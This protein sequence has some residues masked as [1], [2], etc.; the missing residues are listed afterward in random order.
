MQDSARRDGDIDE[1]QD[2]AA[3]VANH[4]DVLAHREIEG[5][6]LALR[7]VLPGGGG[8]RKLEPVG[9]RPLSFQV[10]RPRRTVTVP[11]A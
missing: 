9:P 1:T 7:N 6:R 11:A 3:A 4:K 2:V 5:E 10:W 8:G